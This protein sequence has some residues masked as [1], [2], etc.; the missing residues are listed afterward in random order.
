MA[1]ETTTASNPLVTT[2]VVDSDADITVETAASGNKTL[3]AVEI[4]NPN[5]TEAVYLHMINAAQNS[6]T[7]TQHQHQFYCPAGKSC[8]YYFPVGYLTS[9]GIQFYM[10]TSAGGGQSASSPTES[11]TVKLGFTAR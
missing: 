1:V 8:Y 7:A 4:V 3:Y 5:A 11:V 10:S 2:I 9:T 6:T